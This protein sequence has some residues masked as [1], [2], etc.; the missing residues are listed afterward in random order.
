[1]LYD[2]DTISRNV[3][4]LAKGSH[5]Y[6][7]SFQTLCLLSRNWKSILVFGATGW[8]Q[9]SNKNISKVVRNIHISYY[10]K[11]GILGFIWL[12]LHVTVPIC[13]R[14]A[15]VW[16][17]V[18]KNL[19]FAPGQD[20]SIFSIFNFLKKCLTLRGCPNNLTYKKLRGISRKIMSISFIWGLLVA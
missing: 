20:W 13:L 9:F 2:D 3:M 10:K 16:K 7:L 11:I 14:M 6:G 5:L 4:V 18:S 1:M 12:W 8:V 19:S 15:A 17:K